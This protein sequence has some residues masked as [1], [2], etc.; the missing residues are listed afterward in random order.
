MVSQHPCYAFTCPVSSSSV[1]PLRSSSARSLQ[2]G[3]ESA[4]RSS[5][6]TGFTEVYRSKHAAAYVV[7]LKPSARG[8]KAVSGF[9][10]VRLKAERRTTCPPR[11]RT[12][13]GTPAVIHHT[14]AYGEQLV[15]IGADKVAAMGNHTSFPD[16]VFD[17]LEEK[18]SGG[19][20]ISR[21]APL[22]W[23]APKLYS[24]QVPTRTD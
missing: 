20:Q 21:P 3:C 1:K 12:L 8:A 7:V 4:R 14:P 16:D 15:S 9:Y 17:V 2:N 13:V 23:T 5:S 11:T 22:Q 10:P 6:N 18:T 24:R 19:K